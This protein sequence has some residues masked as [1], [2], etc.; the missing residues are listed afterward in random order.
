AILIFLLGSGFTNSSI[1]TN[2]Y[3]VSEGTIVFTSEAPL[4]FIT[5]S[6]SKLLGAVD[7]SSNSFAFLIPV[8]SFDGFNSELQREHFNE[9]YM[10]SSKY[11]N[12]T[13]SGKISGMNWQKD[14]EYE[15][16]SQGKF[17]IHGVEKER[18]IKGTIVI[19]NNRITI[20][21]KFNVL[22][23]DH[24]IN[25]PTV[26]YQKI[27]ESIDVSVSI[28]LVPKETKTTPTATHE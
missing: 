13:F 24:N 27:S 3:V 1:N 4:E 6:S 22:L 2:V 7:V 9:N 17:T 18:T 10:E 19:K 25:I 14:G 26:V 28:T 12:A 5:A 20:G 21:S 15:M 11:P 16:T 23:K 8:K